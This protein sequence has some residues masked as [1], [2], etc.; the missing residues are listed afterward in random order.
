MSSDPRYQPPTA[1]LVDIPEQHDVGALNPW[2]SMWTRPRAT[3]QHIVDTNPNQLIFVLVPLIGITQALDRAS[4]QSIGDRLSLTTILSIALV[5]GPVLGI[6]SFLIF[7]RLVFWTGRW[8]HGRAPSSTFVLRLPG[9]TF[10][11]SGLRCLGFLRS[12][13][14]ANRCSRAMWGST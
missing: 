12:S 6:A 13:S 1:P 7:S 4:S 2:F 3:I 11:R 10:Q 14:V 9:A 5:L 8:M